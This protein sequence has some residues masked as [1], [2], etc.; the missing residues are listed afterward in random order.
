[1]LGRIVDDR[2]KPVEGAQIFA[3]GG[4]NAISRDDGIF[5]LD[6]LT[7][8]ARAQISTPYGETLENVELQIDT[9]HAVTYTVASPGAILGRV[10]DAETGKPVQKFHVRLENS[11]EELQIRR[12]VRAQINLG[13]WSA[14][15]RDVNAADGRFKI[16][17]IGTA[18]PV[19]IV[20]DAAGYERDVNPRAFARP[21]GQSIE[22]KIEL[23]PIHPADYSSLAVRLLDYRGK[24]IP[25]VQLRLVVSTRDVSARDRLSLRR[26]VAINNNVEQLSQL[27]YVDQFVP[28]TSDADGRHEFTGIIPGRIVQIAYWGAGVPQDIWT[29]G[30]RIGRGK[31]LDIT[32]NVP[33]PAGIH[34]TIDR[35][36]IPDI[37]YVQIRSVPFNGGQAAQQ[38]TPNQS[39]FD[40]PDLAPGEYQIIVYSLQ[41]QKGLNS[42][43]LNMTAEEQVSIKPGEKKE[44]HF[45]KKK[46]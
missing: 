2:G 44:L 17:S 4:E 38:L 13:K 34:I 30:S 25:D 26:R 1:M 21:I 8:K 45:P 7:D 11:S 42:F 37:Y 15:G 33:Q 9:T 22:S 46:P 16:E 3:Y 28:G 27:S 20:I 6:S 29:S 31:K 24:P 23:L 39:S 18:S 12:G 10:V 5:T 32:I 14:P 35:K 43:S 40:Y 41:R 19:E 36:A